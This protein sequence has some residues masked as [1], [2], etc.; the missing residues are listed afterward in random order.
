[1]LATFKHERSTTPALNF[2]I[3]HLVEQYESGQT[4]SIYSYI[5]TLVQAACSRAADALLHSVIAQFVYRD[6]KRAI[7]A[8][9]LTLFDESKRKSTLAIYI[10]FN[11][12]N[13]IHERIPIA[14]DGF[15]IEPLCDGKIKLYI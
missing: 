8:E 14:N 4:P 12:M 6:L 15:I 7:V 1:M 9:I 2:R 5:Y 3:R 10:F 13:S 11:F